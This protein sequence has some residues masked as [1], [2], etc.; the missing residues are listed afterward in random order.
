MN[1]LVFIHS[2]SGGGAER[3]AVTLANHWA[4][5]GWEVTVVTTTG[6]DCDFYTLNARVNRVALELARTS[7]NS[8]MG[9]WNNVRRGLALRR[10]LKRV[11][12]DVA[13]GMMATANVML[14]LA[15]LGLAI[16][17]IGSERIHPPMLPLGRV[18]EAI[19]RWSYSRLYVLVAQTEQSAV[20]L[21]EHAPAPR[22]RVIPNPVNYPIVSHAPHISPSYVKETTGAQRILLAVGRLAHQKGFDR[23]L[24]AYAKIASDNPEWVLVILGEGDQRAALEQQAIDLKVDD[25]VCMPGAV[26]NVGQW[27]EAADIYVL[28][29]RFEGFPNT[30]LEALAHGLPAVAVD[31]DTGPRDILRQGV[32]GLLVPQ[33]DDAALRDALNQ[34]MKDG[35]LRSRFAG[36]A[37]EAQSRFAIDRV[38][39]MWEALFY[40]LRK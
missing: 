30:L 10:V 11:K 15:A 33:A 40:E 8:L 3:V 22:V 6:V 32:D 9:L 1:I 39:G 20:W 2:L 27:F 34:L 23:L 12:P 4:E 5:N 18:W 7:A 35:A 24:D 29:S 37:V 38:A 31:C 19:R 16:P 28:V 25:K 14:A 26:G 13:M 36:R 21:R 17:T